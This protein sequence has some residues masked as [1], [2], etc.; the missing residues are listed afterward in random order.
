[1]NQTLKKKYEELYSTKKMSVAGALEHVHSEDHIVSAMAAAEPRGLLSEL[2]TIADRV[3]DVRISTCLPMMPYDYYMNEEYKG[4][5]LMEGWFYT[6]N[7]RKMHEKQTVSFVPNHLHLAGERRGDH[8]P[9][10]VFVGTASPMD[11]QGYLSLSLSATYE[12]KMIESA[13]TSIIEVNE[14]MPRTFGDTTVHISEIDV[15]VENAFPIPEF[16]SPPPNEKDEVIGKM[17]ADKIEDGSTLQ[18]G[19]GGIPNAVTAQLF[20]KKDLGI[21]TEMFIDGMVD[22][23]E[24]G[25]ITGREKTLLPNRMV[26]TFALGTQKLYDF[27]DDNPGV[28]ILDGRFVNDPYVI[29]QNEKMV[30]INTTLEIDLSGQCS[31]E[32]IGHRQ[33]SGTGGQT[34]TAVGA[35]KSRG[36]KSFIAL[37]STADIRVPGQEERKTISKI[38]PSLTEGAAV[39]LSRNDV[40]YVVTE[41]GI[42]KLRGTA[43]HER[44]ERLIAIAHP[45]FREELQAEAEKRMIW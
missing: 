22:L 21:H 11:K 30:S 15:I 19:I 36:G 9:V 37:Y 18:L 24:A 14:N 10:D 12:R 26:A 40:D 43:L 13:R 31:S 5:F 7:M 45:D 34:D 32:A 8:R 25:A 39:S 6:P 42:A 29:G 3:Q 27:I 2:H 28:Q 17:I 44:V 20:D 1:M 33:F 35:Q 38:V 4:N 23:F 41:Y 16:P